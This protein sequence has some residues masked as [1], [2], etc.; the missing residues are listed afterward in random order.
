MSSR[1]RKIPNTERQW[2]SLR[3]WLRVRWIDSKRQ[4]LRGRV[5]VSYLWEAPEKKT[6]HDEARIALHFLKLMTFMFTG[7]PYIG[8]AR[9]EYAEKPNLTLILEGE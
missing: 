1:W 8:Q 3:D 9:C 4:P 2:L 5:R 7:T 6:P